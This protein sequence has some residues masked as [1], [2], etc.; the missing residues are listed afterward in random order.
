MLAQIGVGQVQQV[1][2]EEHEVVYVAFRQ[3]GLQRREIRCTV[4]IECGDLAVDDAV[5]KLR[6]QLG[7]RL[8]LVGPVE[9]FARL[10]CR[11]AVR[12]AQLHAIAIELRLV[13][14]LIA[15]RRLLDE[16]A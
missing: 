7:D 14:P 8:K 6:R 16:L 4:R 3:R 1:E 10:Q 15:A 5:G 13:R 9:T 12:D 11:L 2:R